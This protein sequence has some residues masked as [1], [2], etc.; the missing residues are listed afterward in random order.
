VCVSAGVARSEREVSVTSPQS[1]RQT[2]E[3]IMERER[4]DGRG[5]EVTMRGTSERKRK[6]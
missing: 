5:R 6:Q 4:Q 2:E 1:G 3:G